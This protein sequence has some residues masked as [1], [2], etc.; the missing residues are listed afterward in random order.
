MLSCSCSCTTWCYNEYKH[1]CGMLYCTETCSPFP[2]T[3]TCC[4]PST[5]GETCLRYILLLQ[6]ERESGENTWSMFILPWGLTDGLPLCHSKEETQSIQLH[7]LSP[8]ASFRHFPSLRQQLY[9]LCCPWQPCV[10]IEQNYFCWIDRG[11]GKKKIA[12]VSCLLVCWVEKLKLC[13]CNLMKPIN[14]CIICKISLS[15]IYAQ[16]AQ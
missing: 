5:S 4:K 7:W 8:S 13:M 3:L 16:F 10:L 2:L 1:G 12:E 9:T 15:Y 6:R 14:M 11:K